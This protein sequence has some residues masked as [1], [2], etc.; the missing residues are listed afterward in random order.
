MTVASAPKLAA[1]PNLQ[2]IGLGS[3]GIG[4]DFLTPFA[5]H[6]ALRDLSVRTNNN[7][8]D[9]GIAIAGSIPNLTDLNVSDTA[10]E[11][12][13]LP[14][15]AEG[16]K[17]ERFT[18]RSTKLTD[19]NATSGLPLLTS[20]RWLFIWK[21]DIGDDTAAAIAGMKSLEVLYLDDTKVTDAGL[22]T[23]AAMP[24]MN[25][26]W[27]SNTAITDDGLMALRMENLESLQLNE[28]AVTDAGIAALA[29]LPKVRSISA[30]KTAITDEGIAAAI[31]IAGE[32]RKMRISH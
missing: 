11:G 24:A 15:L 29:K 4:D 19:A 32:D 31:A 28:T 2:K 8:T 23:M 9:V 14:Q 3:T 6:P 10:F 17:L 7:I 25:N 1:L 22:K 5:G 13:T 21:N 12:A 18:A 30:R 20:L 26:L 27:L 16:G